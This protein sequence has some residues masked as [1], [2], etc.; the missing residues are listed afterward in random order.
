MV[1]LIRAAL[2]LYLNNEIRETKKEKFVIKPYSPTLDYVHGTH[3][4]QLKLGETY[5]ELEFLASY[6]SVAVWLR[7]L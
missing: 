1:Y 6:H 5:M 4:D 3:R 2:I 7:R